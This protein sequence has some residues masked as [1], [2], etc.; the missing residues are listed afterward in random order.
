MH[1]KSLTDQVST[2]TD[3]IVREFRRRHDECMFEAFAKHGFSKE[4]L[5][6]PENFKRVM[7]V[8]M[9]CIGSINDQRIYSVDDVS[10]FSITS[11]VD[12]DFDEYKVNMSFD[13]KH[14]NGLI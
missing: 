11:S 12:F 2:L 9:G 1:I 5:F 7:V 8:E 6:N 13:V 3:Q 4:W 14:H 10:L